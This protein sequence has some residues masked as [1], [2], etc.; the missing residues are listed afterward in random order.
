MVKLERVSAFFISIMD[1]I[2]TLYFMAKIRKWS[3]ITFKGTYF[4]YKVKNGLGYFTVFPSQ[5]MYPEPTAI[6]ASDDFATVSN[7]LC[8]YGLG[9]EINM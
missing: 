6:S 5:L 3:I 4:I 1:F 8:K 2:E 9:V 7:I